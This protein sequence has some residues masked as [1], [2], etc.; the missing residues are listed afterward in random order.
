MRTLTMKLRVTDWPGSVWIF[1]SMSRRSSAFTV[2]SDG[3]A[4]LPNVTVTL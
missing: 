2:L 1:S 4:L 3:A